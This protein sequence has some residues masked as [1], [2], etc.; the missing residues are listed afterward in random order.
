M[1]QHCMMQLLS[2]E[3]LDWVNLKDLSLDWIETIAQ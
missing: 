1:M 2:T 3:I